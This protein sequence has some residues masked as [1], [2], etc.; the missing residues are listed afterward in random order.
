[1]LRTTIHPTIYPFIYPFIY[2]VI[3]DQERI[4][5]TVFAPAFGVVHEV[6]LHPADEA[7]DVPFVHHDSLHT[8]PFIR[9]AFPVPPDPLLTSSLYI[10]VT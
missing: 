9:T 1:M 3:R 10:R 2:P 6:I 8:R 7:F 5:T 4:S